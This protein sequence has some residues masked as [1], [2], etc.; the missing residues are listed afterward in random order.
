MKRIQ[1]RML[2]VLTVS[3]IIIQACIAWTWMRTD[4]IDQ[5]VKV[6]RGIYGFIP[7]WSNAVFS[8]REF[9]WIF[10]LG[11]TA[12]L[13]CILLWRRT[14]AMLVIVFLLTL[15]TTLGMLNAMYPVAQIPRAVWNI[16]AIPQP[17]V[18]SLPYS[19]FIGC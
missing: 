19:P 13:G 14:K 11:S 9:C 8:T 2:L 12:L 17:A 16:R 3:M 6:F 1:N 4:A 18:D 15:A 7:M 5:Y 10:P